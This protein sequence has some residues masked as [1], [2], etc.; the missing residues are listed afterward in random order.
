[1]VIAEHVGIGW[2]YRALSFVLDRRCI[3]YTVQTLGLSSY[4]A[5]RVGGAW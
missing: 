5:V 3:V 4:A 2:E 1:M